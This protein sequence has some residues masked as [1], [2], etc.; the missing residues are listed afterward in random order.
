MS[1]NFPKVIQ[2]SPIPTEILSK[3]TETVAM[4]IT[5]PL[6]METSSALT[7]L[8]DQLAANKWVEAA[9]SWYV[10]S[11]HNLVAVTLK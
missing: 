3:W 6:S 2:M 11:F 1:P 8:G 4:M 10:L 5:S 9:H 7:T